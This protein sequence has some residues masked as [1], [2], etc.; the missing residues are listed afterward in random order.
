MAKIVISN[1]TG[2]QQFDGDSGLQIDSSLSKSPL[3]SSTALTAATTLVD[4]G[5]YTVS[6]GGAL[7]MVMPLASSVPGAQFIV[8]NLSAHAHALT[9]S[10]EAGGTKVF[11][12]GTSR[13]SKIALAAAVGNSVTLVSDGVNFCVMA[14]SGSLTISGG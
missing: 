6:G 13:G 2:I 4:G 11:T 12:D 14:N 7:T 10:A 1:S 5:L 9:G 8:R 3:M